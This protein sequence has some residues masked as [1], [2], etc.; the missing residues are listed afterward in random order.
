MGKIIYRDPNVTIFQS[1]LYQ[2][3][4]TVVKTDDV[5]MVVDPAWL[6]DEVADIRQYVES[7]RGKRSLF[8]MFT[9]SDFDHIV[10]YRA[11][12][13]DKVFTTEALISNPAKEEILQQ[14]IDFDQQHYIQRSYPLEYPEGDFQV[15]RDGVQFR[16]GNTKMAFYLTPGHTAD[17]MMVVVW[18]LGLCI[19]GDYLSNIEFP[20]IYHNS[21]AYEQTLEK[22]PRIHDR[23]WFTRLV[24]GHGDPAL[25][26]TDWLH[27]RTESL[28]YIYALRE[29]VA[30]GR[31]FD[32]DALWKRYSFPRALAKEH[33]NN[34]ALLQK[35]YAAGLW[36]W[37]PELVMMPPKEPLVLGSGLYKPEIVREQEEE[38]EE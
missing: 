2:T 25:T 3:N 1:A 13:A 32:L 18:Q 23:N 21:V 28:A 19:A 24:P 36:Q 7:I 15:Y 26:I 22:M 38:E 9:H 16:H 14:L 4:S 34:L 27:R 6:P 30:T 31:P 37:D 33:E 5:V 10:G 35:E 11:F 17:S 8:L 29:S 12:A 20:F